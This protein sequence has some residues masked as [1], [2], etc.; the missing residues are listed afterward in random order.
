MQFSDSDKPSFTFA[1][2]REGLSDEYNFFLLIEIS[3]L[4]T[5]GLH[6]VQ[7]PKVFGTETDVGTMIRL[8]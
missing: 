2:Q 4:V 3:T 5:P 7:H 1:D 6:A 8:F